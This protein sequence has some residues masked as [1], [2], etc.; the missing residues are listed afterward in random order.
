M[1]RTPDLNNVAKIQ[2]TIP[3]MEC[4]NKPYS[5]SWPGYAIKKFNDML[6]LKTLVNSI[7]TS[8]FNLNVERQK[9]TVDLPATVSYNGT[10]EIVNASD[11]VTYVH[12]Q[13]NSTH[14]VTMLN[15]IISS[16]IISKETAIHIDNLN[17]FPTS[18][19]FIMNYWYFNWTVSHDIIFNF[20]FLQ[21]VT[22]FFPLI[23]WRI[24]Y[25]YKC[26]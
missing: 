17:L 18:K 26:Q 14:S 5:S 25:L 3:R 19:H 11:S 10:Y 13:A 6:I 21:V 16:S 7:S 15:I 1:L 22:I 20:I 9:I 24:K 4:E 23:S 8:C 2:Q 12:S